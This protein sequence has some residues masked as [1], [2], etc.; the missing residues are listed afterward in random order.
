MR[1]HVAGVDLGHDERHVRVHAPDAAVVDDDAAALF[2]S[3]RH[4][5]AD[6]VV[7]G[8]ERDVGLGEDLW[9]GLLHRE[10]LILEEHLLADG[11]WGRGEAKPLHGESAL[12]QHGQ[13][14]LADRAGGARRWLLS[15]GPRLYL[16]RLAER[17]GVNHCI[18]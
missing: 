4:V 11:A 9:R 2:R 15:G 1:V 13:G 8:D 5:A 16:L 14:N 3:E 12:L 10:L 17:R 6:V 7:G 18:T